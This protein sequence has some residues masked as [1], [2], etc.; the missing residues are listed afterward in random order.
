[1]NSKRTA[2]I[3][4]VFLFV[5]VLA[6]Q[7]WNQVAKPTL[8]SFSGSF[9][10]NAN[11]GWFVGAKGVIRKTTDGGKTWGDV[12][13]GITDDLKSVYFLDANTGFIGT[14][15]KLYKSVN[16][17]ATWTSVTL[18]GAIASPT[19]NDVYFAD[20]SKGWVLSSSS[21]LG[22]VLKTTDGGTTWTTSVDNT[23][24]N[25]QT[26]KIFGSTVGV[27]AGGGTGKCDIYYT[28][29]GTAWTKTTA[30]TFPAGIYTRTDIRGLFILDQNTMFATGWGSSASGL[31]PSIHLK[32]TDGGV[33]WTYLSQDVANRTYDN[34]YDMY[35]KNS[36]NG[37]AVGGG[38]KSGILL[39]TTDGGTNWIPMEIPCGAQIS[40]IF[41]VGDAIICAT[42]AG[43]F[44]A[45]KDFGTTWEILTQI[46]IIPFASIF[47]VNNNVIY[48]GGQDGGFLK[49]TD[50]GKN[51]KI[52]YQKV[53][54]SSSNIQ[55]MYFVNENIGYTANS[56]RMI[57]K[58]TDGGV[59]WS[60]VYKDTTAATQSNYGVHFLNENTG[61]VVGKL[62]TNID[63]IYK[64]T[65]GGTDWTVTKSVAATNLRGVAFYDAQ[66]GIAV[67]EAMKA[68]YTKD[69]G[70]T[71]TASVISG[72]PSM[73]AALREV[74]FLNAT[75]AVA[76]GD[77][78]F[79]K[80]TDGGATWNYISVTVDQTL[81]GI[82]STST[83]IWAVGAKTA[84]PKST[85]IL[86][87]IDAGTSW[88]NKVNYAVFDST[89]TV[90]DVT[91]APSGAVYVCAG[92]SAI[93]SSAVL[94]TGPILSLVQKSIDFGQVKVGS[95]KD[96]VITVK[97]TGDDTLKISAIQSTNASSFLSLRNTIIV[98][99]G[100]TV[101]DTLR[102]S[103]QAG[104]T[105]TAKLVI[106]SN[107][108]SAS[109]TIIVTGFGVTAGISY[110]AKTISFGTVKVGLKKDSLITVTNTGNQTLTISKIES[111]SPVFTVSPV[112]YTVAASANIKDTVRFAPTAQ[113]QFSASIVISHSAGPNDTIQVTGNGTLTG[114]AGERQM[115]TIYS[116]GQNYPNPFNPATTISYQL[117][118]SGNVRLT[119]YNILGKE[120]ATLVSEVMEPGYYSVRFDASAV[121]SGLY[122]YR[123]QANNYSDVKKMMLIK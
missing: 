65:N 17:F 56:Y 82:A 101:P 31:Q 108:L 50:G 36:L 76:A 20:T 89:N 115:P 90:V 83:S 52:L 106:T 100:A 61:F 3:I 6:A 71:W 18:T 98:A 1:M 16:G 5:S 33:T 95:K 116:L 122:F 105:V 28:K 66:N 114:V 45:S 21:T 53:N 12:N 19:Y 27:A 92:T 113:G 15:T 72:V 107:A 47:A 44:L 41:G 39:K 46:P 24:G 10:L 32:S 51:W 70:T 85:G 55:G 13:S 9:F 78:V 59:T 118:L 81:T 43:A 87:S 77:K 29:D 112:Q 80:T 97:N 75:T 69:G 121:S 25:L 93:Y 48:A 26:M 42:S 119:V 22:R 94:T 14:T 30:P 4:F 62:G 123:L 34:M 63:A 117:P 35:F 96:S 58:T 84:S 60:A 111:S 40:K 73:T 110:S 103:P 68:A 74:T 49:T 7:T 38:T 88:T 67:G 86:Q 109:D 8:V 2:I 11:T 102:F 79:I 104:G 54:N 57:A 91:I 120:I 37:L 23:A 64:T 99:P